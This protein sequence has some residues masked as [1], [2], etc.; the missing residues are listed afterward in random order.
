[1]GESTR[2]ASGA[3]GKRPSRPRASAAATARPAPAVD[4][5][6][7]PPADERPPPL[8]QVALCPICAT[9]MLLGDVQPEL[10]DHLLAAGREVLL[11]MRTIIDIRLQEGPPRPTTIQRL[12]IH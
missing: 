3:G 7:A 4:E 11:A 10:V 8:C 9:V 1:M 2:R 5:A 12:T 6:S